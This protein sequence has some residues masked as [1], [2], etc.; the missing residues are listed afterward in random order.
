MA[1]PVAILVGACGAMVGM[2]LPT[3][4]P[5]RASAPASSPDGPGVRWGHGQRPA[6]R[7]P[8]KAT[9]TIALTDVPSSDGQ[10]H[11]TADV[12]L[13]PANLVS[14]DPNWVSVLGW[15][16]GLANAGMFVDHLERGPGTSGPPSRYRSPVRGRR[17][18]GCTTGACLPPC[19]SSWPATLVS[20]RRKSRPRRRPATF[21]SRDHH[22][23]AGAQPRHH[24]S[25]WFIGLLGRA[26]VHAGHGRRIAWG[27]GRINN[28]RRQRSNCNRPHRHDEVIRTSSFW[29]ITRSAC[30]SSVRPRDPGGRSGGLHRDAR[31]AERRREPHSENS[32]DPGQDGAP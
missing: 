14:D 13:T 22:P 29:P 19:R 1:V 17:C 2:V 15:Q 32:G 23:A 21:V 30:D 11:A 6:L 8:R 28:R 16:G 26:R 10:R 20:A 24:P 5:F 12:Q 25:L 27:A 31:T 4:L 7:R 18:C 9:A 3:G